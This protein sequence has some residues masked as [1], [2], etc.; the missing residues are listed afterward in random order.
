MLQSLRTVLEPNGLQN[1]TGTDLQ[2][3]SLANILYELTAGIMGQ[4]TRLHK[5]CVVENPRSSLFWLTTFWAECES[6]PILVYQSQQACSLGS[7][8]PKWTLLAA[9]FQSI[10]TVTGLCPGDHKHEP[11]GLQKQGA[12][13]VFATAQEVHYPLALCEA[14][15]GV[16]VLEFVARGVDIPEVLHMDSAAQL[17][18]QQQTATQRVPAFVPEFRSKVFILC[19]ATDECVW[20]Q[21]SPVQPHFR[22]LHQ[23]SLGG[24]LDEVYQQ[25]QQCCRLNKVSC[26]CA[27]DD[28]DDAR[29]LTFF[30][31]PW[32]PEQFVT[33]AMSTQHP[34]ALEAALPTVM[35]D[36]LE[37]MTS[38]DDAAIAKQISELEA[39]E[40]KLRATMDPVVCQATKGK[41]IVLFEQMLQSLKFPDMAVID[42][43]RDGCDLVGDVALTHMLPE[44]FSPATISEE[45][46][47]AQAE[48]VRSQTA[49]I[50]CSCG[51]DEVDMAVWE[52]TLRE[53]QDQWL[54]GPMELEQVPVAAPVSRRFGIRQKEKIRLID[55]L[56]MAA[57]T[58]V[59]RCMRRRCCIRL[60]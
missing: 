50:A 15:V 40:K 56:S 24:N 36:H 5:L 46:L 22:K 21:P 52:Q 57:L 3:V 4:C 42:E 19:N 51:D 60:T 18:A 45:G 49:T 11:W 33:Q 53:V 58:V 30:G 43:L 7:K 59:S 9:N 38:T 47:C 55:D 25:V 17:V 37:Q 31:V 6:A 34:F 44:K 27:K 13:R 14:I 20:P 1:L 23:F 8:R 32:E 29:S 16:F 10:T 2:R 39:E 41:R 54:C 35:L 26:L 12:K 28:C 48:L